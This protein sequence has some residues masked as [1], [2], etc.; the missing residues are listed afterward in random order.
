MG[1]K[2]LLEELGFRY[3]TYGNFKFLIDDCMIDVHF[4]NYELNGVPEVCINELPLPTIEDWK[5]FVIEL[6]KN[7]KDYYC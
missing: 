1:N 6:I 2:K 4:D 3:D 5:P 7:A